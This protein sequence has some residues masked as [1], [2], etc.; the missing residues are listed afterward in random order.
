MELP[1][2]REKFPQVNQHGMGWC[3]PASFEVLIH[4][5]DIPQPK[6]ED[7]VLEYDK[8][9]GNEG[10]AEAYNTNSG[11]KLRLIK[12]TNPT[13]DQLSRLGFPK[14]NFDVFRDIANALLPQGC[15]R[16]FEHPN[17]CENR[18]EH[19]LNKSMEDGNGFLSVVKSG[20][21]NCH[22]MPVIGYDGTNVTTYDPQSG[23]IAT[24]PQNQIPFN[25]DCIIFKKTLVAPAAN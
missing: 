9:F 21:G 11:V 16:I 18:F 15:G 3:I 1:Q 7:M 6:Q 25:R 14:A 4:Y 24:K 19:Y 13:I 2:A 17:D 22:I 5:F 20:D 23:S 12:L 8:R 10:Y